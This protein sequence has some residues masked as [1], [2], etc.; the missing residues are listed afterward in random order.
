MDSIKLVRLVTGEDLACKC[1]EDGEF[2]ELE[3]CVVLMGMGEGQLAM[4]PFPIFAKKKQMRVRKE[5]ILHVSELE[6]D[7]FNNYNA[8]YGSGLVLARGNTLP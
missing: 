5:H 3:N 6:E 8:K 1:T 7:I 4:I 2:V